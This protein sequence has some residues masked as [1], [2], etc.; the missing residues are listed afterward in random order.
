MCGLRRLC[1]EVMSGRGFGWVLEIMI[2]RS[3][4]G[5]RAFFEKSRMTK[6][7]RLPLAIDKFSWSH[8]SCLYSQSAFH[9]L[10]KCAEGDKFSGS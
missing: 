3:L 2:A 7:L 5:W 6:A 9:E 8:V 10:V 4:G 1:S